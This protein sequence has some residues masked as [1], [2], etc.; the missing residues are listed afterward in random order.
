L[1]C[2]LTLYN[3]IMKNS[4]LSSV[5]NQDFSGQKNILEVLKDK[6]QEKDQIKKGM[7]AKEI[8]KVISN[9]LTGVLNNNLSY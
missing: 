2:L 4:L 1:K 7:S 6:T 8:S 5:K 3:G 9:H